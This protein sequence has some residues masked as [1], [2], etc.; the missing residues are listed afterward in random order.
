MFAGMKLAFTKQ[1]YFKP[2]YLP[3]NGAANILVRSLAEELG[4]SLN[5]KY[6]IILAS[7]LAIAK[8]VNGQAFDWWTGNDNKTL[9]LWSLF[10]HVSNQSVMEVYKLLRENGY[11]GAMKGSKTSAIE[12]LAVEK[13]NW[14]TAQRLPKH[15]MEEATFIESN[16]PFVMVNQPETYE[17]KKATKNQ[18]FAAPKLSIKKVKQEFGEE[19]KLAYRSVS[20][21][22]AYWS[23]HPLYNPIANEFYSSARRIFHNGSIKSGGCWY[24]GWTDFNSNQR[25]S[26]TIDG[27]PVVQV[28]VN[29]MI[30][31][32]LSSLTGKPMNMIGAFQDVYQAVLSQIPDTKNSRDKLK[33]VIIELAGSGNPYKE[34]PSSDCEILENID[35]FTHIRDLCLEAYPALKCLDQERFNFTNDLSF[36]EAS[37]LTETL[38]SLK[39][40]GV[41]AYPAH[42]CLIVRMG[43]E[44]DAVETFKK[45]FKDYVSLFQKLNKLPELY[46]DIA[47]TI[48]FD[49]SE[50]VRIQ[51]ASS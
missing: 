17:D 15:F 49:P 9:K 27:H 44:F 3:S 16:L 29:A 33:Q 51:G 13:P 20:E 50:Q 10:P 25:C 38:L 11:I 32:L 18:Y 12:G 14:I 24:G 1:M 34:K 46:L 45:V 2:S 41:V 23:Q 37:I 28:D 30:L 47:L 40:I 26:F 6:E 43:D 4:L 8:K 42:D 39:Q 7:F 35:E 31:C 5:K 36:H 19:Y 22:N 48:K 21:M